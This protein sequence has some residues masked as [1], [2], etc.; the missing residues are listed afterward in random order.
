MDR[1]SE[2]STRDQ[3]TQTTSLASPPMYVSP[4]YPQ[5][6]A[7]LHGIVL[8]RSP[9]VFYVYTIGTNSKAT[10]ISKLV[11]VSQTRLMKRHSADTSAVIAIGIF[12][13]LPFSDLI[14]LN[15]LIRFDS[16]FTILFMTRKF[17]LRSTIIFLIQVRSFE[18]QRVPQRL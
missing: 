7:P 18:S 3:V 9:G 10:N 14:Q 17:L 11:T 2:Q 4:G 15:F 8:R 1:C 16:P 12:V 5:C 6:M 13:L